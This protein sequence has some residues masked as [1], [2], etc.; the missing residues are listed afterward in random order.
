MPAD[1][2]TKEQKL[3]YGKYPKD[4]N[5]D[6]L[7]KYFYLDN[8][9]KERILTCRRNYNQLGYALQLTTVRFIGTF[10]VNPILLPIKTNG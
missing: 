1:F 7:N 3:L 6:Q 2:L 8:S 9:D 4:I 10:L 5:D